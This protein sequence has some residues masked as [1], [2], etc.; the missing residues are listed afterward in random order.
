MNSI[1][2]KSYF[3]VRNLLV[4]LIPSLIGIFLF[5][6]PVEGED[7]ITLPVAYLA[8]LLS[9]V[10][11]NAM[12][13]ILLCVLVL[14]ALLTIVVT[15]A[16]PAAIMQDPFL[17]RLFVVGPLWLVVRVLGAIFGV[18]TF[19]QWGTETV[20]GELTGQIVFGD[21]LPILF[22]VFLFAGL[23]LPLLL[24]FGLLELCGALLN[25]IMRPLFKLPGR[26][27]VDCLASWMGDGTVGVLLSNQQYEQGHYT[28]R[29]A[30]VVAT[31]FSVVSI[32]FTIVILSYVELQHMFWQYYGTIVLAGLAAAIISPRI[33]PLSRK[34]DT[35]IDHST[36]EDEVFPKGTNLFKVGF[37]RA[38]K[39]AA[40][41]SRPSEHVKTG[42]QNVLDMWLGVIPVVMAVGTLALIVAELTPVFTW[43]G[44]PFVPVLELM[45]VPEAA[46]AGPTMVI[47][48]ADMLLP[49]ILAGGIESEMTRF[50]IA[51]LSVTQLIY[52]SETGG[53]LL[54]SKLPVN[55]LD[56]VLIFIVRTIITLPIIVMMA[57][58]FF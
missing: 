23:L 18:M 49:A 13:V 40:N 30:A 5:M 51:C 50:I 42:L 15:L 26:S 22:A 46:A 58:I 27:S 21:L 9:G 43:L 24:N 7:G 28:K 2:E 45:Q 52:L 1:Q 20:W 44:A 55:F 56:L 11:G 48:F 3:S 25:R 57:H 38:M 47:G 17:K 54:A 16:K 36:S 14:S 8:N 34:A 31:T 19:F 39:V 53:L 35:Y 41:T 4:F 37:N 32:T 29:E 12:A 33:P 10:L 6:V